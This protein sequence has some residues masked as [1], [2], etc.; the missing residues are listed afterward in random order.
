M[1]RLSTFVLRH[2][3]LVGLLWLAVLLAGGATASKVSG[4]LSQEFSLPGS[5]SYDANQAIL[6]AYGNGAGSVPLVPVITLPAGTTVDSPGVKAALGKA[7]GAV[8]R[9]PR[10][11]VVAYT[12]TGD[13]RFVSA[14]GRTTFGLVFPPRY[15]AFSSP[16]LGPAVTAA[17]RPALPTGATVRVTGIDELATNHGTSRG[18]NGVLAETLLGGLGALAVLA[19]VFGSLLAFLPLLI[20]AVAILATFLVILGLTTF[21]DINFI[22]QFLVALIGLGVAIDYSLLLVTRWREERAHGHQGDEAVRRAMATAGRW[23][24]AASPWRSAC[25]R[26]WSCRCRSC[27]ASALAAC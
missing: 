13:R 14:D 2:R 24:S 3:L 20:A 10:L 11:R 9:D 4:R 15:G 19:F 16:D 21:T 18:D 8:A 1:T 7:F 17:L 12:S 27:A 23:C 26:W 25:S 22:V 6:R 5:K